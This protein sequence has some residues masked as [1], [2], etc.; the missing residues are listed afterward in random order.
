MPIFIFIV[1]ISKLSCQRLVNEDKYFANFT[2]LNSGLRQRTPSIAPFQD[3]WVIWPPYFFDHGPDEPYFP[4]TTT[5]KYVVNESRERRICEQIESL[6]I[7][8]QLSELEVGYKGFADTSSS[9]SRWRW[10]AISI[11]PLMR[12]YLVLLPQIVVEFR[13]LTQRAV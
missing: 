4:R 12:S 5:S 13:K 7:D 3:H 1:G 11:L 9:D 8:G 2:L 6:L 10:I